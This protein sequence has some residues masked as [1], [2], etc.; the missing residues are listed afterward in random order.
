MRIFFAITVLMSSVIWWNKPL[1]A[2]ELVNLATFTSIPIP[3]I[4]VQK[5]IN[6]ITQVESKEIINYCAH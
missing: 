6:I 3:V 5:N 4:D 2:K 1:W